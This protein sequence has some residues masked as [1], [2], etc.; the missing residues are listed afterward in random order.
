M[1]VLRQAV[2]LVP[3]DWQRNGG[4]K[5]VIRIVVPL[6][7]DEPFGVAAIAF[8]RA[9]QVTS[10][11][12]DLFGRTVGPQIGWGLWL[13]LIMSL[14]LIVTAGVVANQASKLKAGQR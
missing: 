4:T 5:D 6:G 3:S 8:R 11:K 7:F 9:V 13:V 14:V 1:H 10:R 2:S 12:V